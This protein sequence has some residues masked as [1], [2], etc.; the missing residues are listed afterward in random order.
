MHKHGKVEFFSLKYMDKGL[1]HFYVYGYY[2]MIVN[3]S[4]DINTLFRHCVTN[5][6]DTI[7]KHDHIIN[8]VY[9][10]GFSIMTS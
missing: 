3:V 2:K 5:V 9:S 4:K 7:I 10:H 6:M 1:P 8:G